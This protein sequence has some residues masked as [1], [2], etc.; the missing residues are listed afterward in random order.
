[1]YRTTQQT[2]CNEGQKPI[3]P[4]FDFI[5]LF[6]LLFL[7]YLLLSFLPCCFSTVVLVFPTKLSSRFGWDSSCDNSSHCMVQLPWEPPAAALLFVSNI[8]G[9]SM[10]A[11][12]R[13]SQVSSM[14]AI[15]TKLSRFEPTGF[16][17]MSCEDLRVCSSSP[18]PKLKKRKPAL[19]I[20]HIH[21]TVWIKFNG[22]DLF[23][24]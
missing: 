22:I 20:F 5:Y 1:M 18:A 17:L 6:P 13:S 4:V 9:T 3:L 21:Q 12:L 2:Q 8:T 16:G 7:L 14:G 24:T 10:E 15:L 19:C 23:F 11:S